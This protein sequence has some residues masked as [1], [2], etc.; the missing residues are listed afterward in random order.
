MSTFFNHINI[1]SHHSSDL[2]QCKLIPT[3]HRP[4]KSWV[5]MRGLSTQSKM[6]PL[7]HTLWIYHLLSSRDKEHQGSLLCLLLRR[8][9]RGTRNHPSSSK[10]S[11]SYPVVSGRR[12]WTCSTQAALLITPMS[13]PCKGL[14]S[15]NLHISLVT[16]H[17]LLLLQDQFWLP[18][19]AQDEFRDV[20][21]AP[22]K[23]SLDSYHPAYSSRCPF[24]AVHGCTWEWILSNTCHPL[25]DSSVCL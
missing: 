7:F 4:L 14:H 21:T 15:W 18:H 1:P 10:H 2:Q 17:T 12:H 19:M 20:R 25:I 11:E 9:P 6:G 16:N 8:K 23:K 5:S 22:C 13:P 24:H 3:T